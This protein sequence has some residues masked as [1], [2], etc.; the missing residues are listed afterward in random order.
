MNAR[1]L[2]VLHDAG[3]EHVLAVTD[4]INVNLDCVRQIRVDQH[5]RVTRHH[6]GFGDV[7][8]Q[9]NIIAHDFH[10][11]PTQYIRGAND[12]G[13]ANFLGDLFGFGA[14]IGD[15]VFGLAQFDFAHEL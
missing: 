1:F 5:W 7:A 11:A 12:D 15:A 9:L 13:E 6:N 10:G 4:A 2:D 3:D 8:L 14:G